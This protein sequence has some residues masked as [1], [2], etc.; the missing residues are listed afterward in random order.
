MNIEELTKELYDDLNGRITAVDHSSELIIYFRCNDWRHQQETRH[1]KITCH[2]VQESNI[3]PSP[4]DEI[5]FTDTHPLLWKHN[6]PHGYLYYSSA[7]EN[8]YDILGRIWEAHEKAFGGWHP[9][10]DFA[11]IYYS[12]QTMEFCKGSNGQLASGPKPLLDLYQ[13]A[14][15]NRI[16]TNQVTSYTPSG[17]YKALIFDSCFVVCKSVSIHEIHG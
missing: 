7:P 4:S 14:I 6:E 15:G 13:S 12:D 17:G 2:D 11:N 10:T 8:R 9:L 1:F 5:E 3:Q 16:R